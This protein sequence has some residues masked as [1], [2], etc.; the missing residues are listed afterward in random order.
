MDG[1]AKQFDEI[2]SSESS[3]KPL[4]AGLNLMVRRLNGRPSDS[5]L[6]RCYSSRS[7]D[8]VEALA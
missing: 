7:R 2:L 1:V 5:R 8:H 4:I 6:S 3:K